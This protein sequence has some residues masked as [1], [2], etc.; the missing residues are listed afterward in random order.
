MSI[1]EIIMLLCFGAAWPFS[2]YKSY[3]SKDNCGKSLIFLSIVLL[4]YIAGITHKLLFSRDIV[5][6]FYIINSCMVI[7]DIMI[8]IGN[9]KVISSARERFKTI[10]KVK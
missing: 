1:F 3:K 8:F 5:V 7:T 6:V 9:E 10:P 2:I 4:G